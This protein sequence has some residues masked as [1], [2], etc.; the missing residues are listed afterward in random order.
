MT[1]TAAVRIQALPGQRDALL[2]ALGPAFGL[3]RENPRCTRFEVYLCEEDPDRILLIEDWPSAADHFAHFE[4]LVRRGAVTACEALW[5][6]PPE[7]FH[8]TRAG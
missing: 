5:A 8:Y 7:S 2:E 1:V 6:A 3:T 4:D